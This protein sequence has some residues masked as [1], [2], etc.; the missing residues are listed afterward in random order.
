[1]FASL[2]MVHYMLKNMPQGETPGVYLPFCTDN[3]GN[4]YC[5]LNDKTKT[6]PCSAILM[7]L[8]IQ[9]HSC[10]VQLAPAHV[11]REFNTWADGLGKGKTDLF[12]KSK[13]L[14]PD[15][16]P[17]EWEVL[18]SLIAMGGFPS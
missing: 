2:V 18:T 8:L 10:N 17:P 13:Q 15:L 6:W 1:M 9:A 3:E 14:R 7:E 12:S 4:A 5:L 16:S 11:K